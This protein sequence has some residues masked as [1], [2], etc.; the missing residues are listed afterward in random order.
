MH[1]LIFAASLG[2]LVISSVADA[3]VAASVPRHGGVACSMEAKMCPDGKTYVSRRGP[4]CEFAPCP[5]E[6]TQPAPP[7]DDGTGTQAPN[8][9]TNSTVPPAGEPGAT[10]GDPDSEGMD[11]TGGKQ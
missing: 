9:P 3:K 8:D 2:L 11:D 7:P 10:G 1:R 4:N 5:D 6:T